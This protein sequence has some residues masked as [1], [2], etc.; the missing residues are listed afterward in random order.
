MFATTY[1]CEKLFSTMKIVKTKFRSRLTDKYLRDQLRLAIPMIKGKKEKAW[2]EI[3][4]EYQQELGKF[5][6]EKQLKKKV[7]NM[8]AE[9]SQ[10]SFFKIIFKFINL[11]SFS[12]FKVVG[13]PQVFG[14]VMKYGTT[15]CYSRRLSEPRGR[16]ESL[17]TRKNPMTT[18][19]RTPDLPVRS[20]L[21]KQL[22]YPA[23]KVD[24]S[25]QYYR[26]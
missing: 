9:R 4:N 15:N 16:S 17:S 14:Y 23:A 11:I 5:I 6:S 26:N 8:K 20:Q 2:G 18:W 12:C 10:I 1:V 13:I 21:L 3:V 7:Q 19:D 24:G 25:E 22:S